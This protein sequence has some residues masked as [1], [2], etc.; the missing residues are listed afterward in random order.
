MKS[1]IKSGLLA[2][3]AVALPAVASAHPAIGEAAG[4]GHGFAHPISGLDHILAMVMVGVFAFQLGGRA[5]WLVPTI[6]V[7]VMG[8]GGVLG[9]AG[10]NV[11]FVETGIALSVVVL[12][13]I[14]AL[15]V[16]APLATALG[17]IGLFAIFHGY[18]H[19]AEM[20]E[21][22]AAAGYA[23][24]FMVATALL[25]VAGL[26]LGYLIGRAGERQGLFVTRTAGGIATIAGVGILTGLI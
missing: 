22:A 18:A 12:G 14:V 8:L 10:I 11:P 7:L 13:A 26:A 19:G 25:H 1:A 15:H 4:F 2:L 20:P 17:I 24:G 3:A 21:N 5:T 9:I 23:A 6:F 16:K